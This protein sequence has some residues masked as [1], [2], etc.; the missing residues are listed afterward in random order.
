MSIV[1]YR[2]HGSAVTFNY[3]GIVR[4]YWYYATRDAYRLF[5]QTVNIKRARLERDNAA[6]TY[7]FL[8]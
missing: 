1:Y 2:R 5:K 6:I 8:Y 4:T 7:G 3:N